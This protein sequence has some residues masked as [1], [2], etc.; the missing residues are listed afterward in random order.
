MAI[1]L[2]PAALGLAS[3]FLPGLI[4]H[5][6]GKKAGDVAK[7]VT[8]TAAAVTGAKTPEEAMERLRRDAEKQRE[9]RLKLAEYEMALE[10]AEQADRQDARGLTRSLAANK[11]AIAWAAPVLSAIILI[12][13]G[14][15]VYLVVV[16][17]E[18]GNSQVAQ[19]LLGAL[20]SM[21]VQVTNFW[22]GSSRSSQEKTVLLTGAQKPPL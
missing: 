19:I 15:M 6:A 16:T 17:P 4:R 7:V 13:F 21:A 12:A 22:L 14:A 9:L 1:P 20:A 3:E 8:D 10:A 18:G 11:T 2:L 5:L